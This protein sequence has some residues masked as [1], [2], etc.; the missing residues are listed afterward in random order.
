MIAYSATMNSKMPNARSRCLRRSG[1]LSWH[2]VQEQRTKRRATRGEPPPRTVVDQQNQKKHRHRA[3]PVPGLRLLPLTITQSYC[4]ASCDWR[5]RSTHGKGVAANVARQAFLLLPARWIRPS[6][7]CCCSSRRRRPRIQHGSRRCD[8]WWGYVCGTF[9]NTRTIRWVHVRG[10]VLAHA[11]TSTAA[12]ASSA[13][14][15]RTL[16]TGKVSSFHRL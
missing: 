1:V 16:D 13:S 14:R 2:D 5:T 9:Q 4:S 11:M 10:W 8:P 7:A 6:H 3:T 15:I 12:H